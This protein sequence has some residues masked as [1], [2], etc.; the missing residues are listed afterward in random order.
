[1]VP[2]CVK[3]HP[4]AILA[5]RFVAVFCLFARSRSFLSL[6]PRCLRMS[7]TEKMEKNSVMRFT[8]AKPALFT[9]LNSYA[10]G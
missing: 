5:C 8:Q 10:Y 7:S 9:W 3:T 1:M 2:E 6:I 4:G